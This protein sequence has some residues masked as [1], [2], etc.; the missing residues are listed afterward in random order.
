MRRNT[1][2][3]VLTQVCVDPVSCLATGTRVKEINDFF[4]F[5]NLRQIGLNQIKRIGSSESSNNASVY[6]LR[7]TKRVGD[8]DYIAY[9]VLK[10][11]KDNAADNLTYEYV[12]GL[13]VNQLMQQHFPCFVQT[14][15]L[16]RYESAEAKG[17]SRVTPLEGLR[18]VHTPDIRESCRRNDRQCLLVQYLRSPEARVLGDYTFTRQ[19][20]DE[21]PK[22]LYQAYAVLA[23]LVDDFTH[24]DMHS[25]NVMIYE[26]REPLQFH[27]GSFSFC[28]KYLTK[29][30][31]Y[32]R[33]FGKDSRE[34][35]R[36]VCAECSDCGSHFG[37]WFTE[38]EHAAKSYYIDASKPNKSHD[39]IYLNHLLQD[40]GTKIKL[41]HP[42]LYTLLKLVRYDDT[43]GTPPRNSNGIDIL[44]VV[45]AA[46]H[47]KE[48]I[49][50]EIKSGLTEINV[51]I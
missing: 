25:N 2:K 37:Y 38:G 19:F 20:V 44:N 27:Y 51:P 49:S 15:G 13:Y 4:D 50:P 6:C 31:D 46:Q 48:L 35:K 11:T 22:I 42:K 29:I 3:V 36:T 16:Y 21:L 30:I 47:L 18:R 32:G 14:Y 17:R 28:C 40:H 43:F 5:Q 24:Y 23:F 26:M 12:M 41:Y 7:Y 10:T 1:R 34:L 33:A 9:A 8:A 45:D 39:L